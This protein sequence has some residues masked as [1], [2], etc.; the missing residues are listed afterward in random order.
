MQLHFIIKPYVY[1]F[2]RLD[3]FPG[4]I[5]PATRRI[6]KTLDEEA[7]ILTRVW[8]FPL[9]SLPIIAPP[10]TIWFTITGE[11]TA[12]LNLATFIHIPNQYSFEYLS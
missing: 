11:E 4:N 12:I 2:S 1:R 8:V 6:I 10:K 3:S 5:L 9:T 7:F